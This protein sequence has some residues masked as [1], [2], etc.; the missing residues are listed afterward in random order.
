MKILDTFKFIAHALQGI[1]SN[2][3]P[4]KNKR[5]FSEMTSVSTQKAAKLKARSSENSKVFVSVR[6]HL[7]CR[8]KIINNV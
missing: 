7:K 3:S 4:L 6:Q 2:T 1:G 5:S 8:R